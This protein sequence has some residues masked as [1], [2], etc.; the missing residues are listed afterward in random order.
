MTRRWI[1]LPGMGASASM[2]GLLR[3]E[4]RFNVEFAN[5]PRYRGETAYA[6]VAHRLID[7]YRISGEEVVGGSSLGGMVALEI[8][9]RTGAKDVILIGSALH[10]REVQ[11]LLALASPLAAITP[12]AL[13]QALAGKNQN[14]LS[15]MFAESDP[16]FIRAMCSYLPSWRGCPLPASTVHRL[17]GKKDHIIP[18]P[19]SGCEVIDQAGHL[20]AMTHAAETAAF[21]QKAHLQIERV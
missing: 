1:L 10:A 3:K 4:L 6:E 19:H 16:E 5:W 21:L 18:C 13:V 12:M 7:E 2:Y 20:P 9:K 17:H 11:P 8:A 14:L 15:A